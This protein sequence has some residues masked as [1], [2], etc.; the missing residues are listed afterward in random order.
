MVAQHIPLTEKCIKTT[1]RVSTGKAHAWCFSLASQ[2]YATQQSAPVCLICG[3]TKPPQAKGHVADEIQI[4]VPSVNHH[5]R[6]PQVIGPQAVLQLGL[7]NAE[8]GAL[9]TEVGNE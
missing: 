1:I 8:A 3:T 4:T 6:V 5:P 7:S 9:G 2:L